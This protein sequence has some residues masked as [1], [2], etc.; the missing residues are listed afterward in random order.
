MNEIIT[1]QPIQTF[2]YLT[3]FDVGGAS[4]APPKG[5]HSQINS[6]AFL[7][8]QKAMTYQSQLLLKV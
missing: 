1:I 3:L 5:K 6:K 8:L 7:W 2:G 4:M